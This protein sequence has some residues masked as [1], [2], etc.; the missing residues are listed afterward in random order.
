MAEIESHK[1][2]L[3]RDDQARNADPP[4]M[5]PYTK[6]KDGPEPWNRDENKVLAARCRKAMCS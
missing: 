5:V 6:I 4:E 2:Q 1:R 3:P